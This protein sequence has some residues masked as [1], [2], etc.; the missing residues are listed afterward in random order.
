MN[1]Q[2]KKQLKILISAYACEPHQGSEPG[3]GWNVVKE[4]SKYHQVWVLT[5]NC[6]RP[7]IETEITQNPISN[8]H[9]IYLDPFNWY[10]NWHPQHKLTNKV[11]HFHHYLWQIWAYLISRS[12][13]QQ[14]GFDLVH[15]VT[16]VRYSS[17]SF[18]SLLPIPFLWGP[19]GGGE[20]APQSFWKD[21]SLSGKLYENLRNLARWVGEKDPSVHL[22]AKRS[23]VAWATTQDTAQRLQQIGTKNIQI[24]SQLGLSLEEIE[25]LAKNA[26]RDDS[27]LKFISVGRLLH[28]KGFHLG[29]TAFAQ[30]KVSNAE[31]WIIG[32]GRE[33]ANLEK[34]VQ[35]LGISEKV[36]FWGNL[37]REQ[38]LNKIKSCN[39]LVHPSLHESGGFVCLEAMAAGLPVVC[40]DLGGPGIQVTTETGFKI[41]AYTPKQTVSDLAKAMEYLAQDSELRLSMSKAG[42]E[43][44]KKAFSWENKGLYLAQLYRE[45]VAKNSPNLQL[46]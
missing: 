4:I 31:Y 12:L 27:H 15:H 33:R 10:L 34:L 43:R 32:D 21:F 13:H 3:V 9:F 17:P 28:W 42:Q 45:V 5:S 39:V 20:S 36:K 29:L 16:Y 18:V 41:K 38:T 26:L 23:V 46:G 24:H 25:Q 44:V 6:H 1:T 11:V 8:L 14:I 19:V 22:T 40:L 2:N 30:A 35:D 7:G 37:S